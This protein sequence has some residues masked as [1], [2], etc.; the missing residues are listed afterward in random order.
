[1]LT[2]SEVHR[3]FRRL[4]QAGE[5]SP[6]KIDRAESLI[7]QLRL[8]SPLRHRLAEELEEL[9]QLCETQA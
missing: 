1:V 6:E 8:E 7:E 5:V 9:K 4:F 3:S 2:E